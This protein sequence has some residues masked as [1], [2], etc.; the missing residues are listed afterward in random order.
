M[1]RKLRGQ[2][3]ENVGGVSEPGQK[4]QRLASTSP[5]Q[6]LQRYPIY[7]DELFRVRRF[8]NPGVVRRLRD[9][10]QSH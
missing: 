9:R 7:F 5:V 3:I 10:G 6:K 2:I 8:I 1:V 4:D